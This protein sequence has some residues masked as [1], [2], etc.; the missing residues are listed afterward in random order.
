MTTADILQS[1]I[2]LLCA[3]D[4]SNPLV[5]TIAQQY[6]DSREEFDRVARLWTAQYAQ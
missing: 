3:C 6:L 5:P 2:S 4:T 1:I